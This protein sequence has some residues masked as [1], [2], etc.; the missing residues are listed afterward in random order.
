[1]VFSNLPFDVS[2][3]PLISIWSLKEPTDLSTEIINNSHR[4]TERKLSL[5]IILIK[6]L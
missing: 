6:N 2:D 5:F 3:G 4:A 1:M